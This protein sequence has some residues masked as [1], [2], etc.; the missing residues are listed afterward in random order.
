MSTHA[1]LVLDNFVYIH[2][3]L[4]VILYDVRVACD[5]QANGLNPR[6]RGR[7]KFIVQIGRKNCHW[8]ACFE[9]VRILGVPVG[10]EF[11]Q[12]LLRPLIWRQIKGFA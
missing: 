7:G 12:F 6:R 11:T 1:H 8:L 2:R 5:N 3:F 4:I 10:R 9:T